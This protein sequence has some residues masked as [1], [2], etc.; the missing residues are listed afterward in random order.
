MG[1]IVAFFGWP[2]QAS[3]QAIVGGTGLLLTIIGF[4]FTWKG[5]RLA[6]NQIK[7]TRT[8]AEEASRAVAGV[9]LQLSQYEAA[10]DLAKAIQA[11]DRVREEVKPGNWSAVG[12]SYEEVR[13]CFIRLDANFAHGGEELRSELQKAAR[14]INVM[15]KTI[16]G[17]DLNGSAP[18]QAKFLDN[19][20]RHFEIAAR[21]QVFIQ[22]KA[23]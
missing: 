4:G 18:D 3:N 13:R 20:R 14:Q 5:L 10:Q 12:K 11:L 6:Y 15:I 22:G 21:M 19:A 9:K 17:M 2:F 1:Q 7:N 23:F 8:A 16:D